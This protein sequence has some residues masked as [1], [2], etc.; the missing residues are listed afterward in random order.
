MTRWTMPP[1]RMAQIRRVIVLVE[2]A[3]IGAPRFSP[4][5][6]LALC[7]LFLPIPSQYAKSESSAKRAPGSL[8]PSQ[9][10]TYDREHHL[11]TQTA[12]RLI[13]RFIFRCL[14]EI[15]RDRLSPTHLPST[16]RF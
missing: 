15:A 1:A 10:A 9:S 7:D 8:I 14:N 12:S 13:S 2:N 5:R 16:C 6:T 4:Y 3:I 11:G